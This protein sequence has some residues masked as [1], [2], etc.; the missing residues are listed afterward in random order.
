[1]TDLPEAGAAPARPARRRGSS[2]TRRSSSTS[3]SATVLTDPVL[4]H[5]VM[6]LRRTGTR[7]APPRPRPTVVLVSHLHHDHF[8]LPSLAGW[9]LGSVIVVPRGPSG[10]SGGTGSPTWCRWARASR[11]GSA[12]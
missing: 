4:R 7:P 8:D 2:A 5:R 11:T 9:A 12:G 6:F 3:G 10:C 1:M